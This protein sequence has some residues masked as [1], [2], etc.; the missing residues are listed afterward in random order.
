MKRCVFCDEEIDDE[1]PYDYC[2]NTECY[3]LGFKQA[4]YVVL[5][6]HKS[7]PIICSATDNLV[8]ANKSYMNPK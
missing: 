8:T 6:V 3:E 4:E 2:L 5:G 7:T 1:R